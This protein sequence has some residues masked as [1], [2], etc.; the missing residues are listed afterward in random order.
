MAD[1]LT[2]DHILEFK[3][4]FAL[5]DP[6]CDGEIT[7]KELAKVLVSL[8]IQV[9]KDEVLE[10]LQDVDADGNGSIDF[11][12]FLTLLARK[13]KDS[14]SEEELKEAFRVFDQDGSG[15]INVDEFRKVMTNLREVISEKELEEM[16][17]DG[18]TD[19]DGEIN[20][21]EFVRMMMR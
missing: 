3:E 20:Y 17:R 9:T 12:E 21:E 13:L 18:D 10:M 15:S 7:H 1:Q 19:G 16:I 6:D 8:G 14:D 4:A 11:P 2:E 5:F